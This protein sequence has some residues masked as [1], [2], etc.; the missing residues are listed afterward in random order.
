MPTWEKAVIIFT[1]GVMAFFFWKAWKWR[2]P[3]CQRL[4]A[5]LYVRH[6][7]TD[8]RRGYATVTRTDY[9]TSRNGDRGTIFREEQAVVVRVTH[10][11]D[12]NCRYCNKP[13][14][15]M[16]E[17]QYEPS[18]TEIEPPKRIVEPDDHDDWQYHNDYY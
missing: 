13:A 15:R 18:F 1:L 9:Y 14:Y 12:Y 4:N 3:S 5:L 7:E 8:R 2:C 11:Y 16:V 17:T 10:R 6:Y